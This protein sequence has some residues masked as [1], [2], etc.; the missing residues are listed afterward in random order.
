M[1][2]R[3]NFE[4]PAPPNEPFQ[5]NRTIGLAIL[6]LGL[7]LCLLFS[8]GADAVILDP[9]KATIA[10]TQTWQA[11]HPQTATPAAT[12]TS[13]IVPGDPNQQV[14][15]GKNNSGVLPRG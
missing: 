6:F 3:S 4:Q 2:V 13:T 9:F 11:Q 5:D 8:I 12:P 10:V 15:G 7:L 14:A 1:F